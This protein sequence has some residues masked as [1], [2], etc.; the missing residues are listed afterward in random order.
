MYIPAY[1]R[2][3]DLSEIKS[4]IKMNSFGILINCHAK[5]PE[6]THIPME[7]VEQN[8][9]L[10]L[11]GHLSRANK[12]WENFTDETNVLSIFQGPHTYVSSSWYNH[13]NVP[14]WNYIA[15]HI[16]G[17]I[18][19]INEKDLYQSLDQLMDKYETISSSPIK[20]KDMPVE[21]ID[22]YMKG[23]VGFRIEIEKIEGKWKMSQNRN[24][25]DFTN[26]I[27]ELEKLNNVNAGLIANEMKRMN[28]YKWK[29]EI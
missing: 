25:E 19:I 24:E 5:I 8:E 4:F 2:N 15:V 7:L 27:L 23:I 16:Y 20:L 3:N 14:T 9:Q 29:E 6:A 11:E 13:V 21:L 18:K 12:Q 26:I 10:F 1:F 22:K 17:K 28:N